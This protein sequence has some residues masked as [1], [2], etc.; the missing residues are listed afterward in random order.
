MP[1]GCI[2]V[3]RISCG[4]LAPARVPI[5]PPTSTA[6][7]FMAVPRPMTR[8]SIAGIVRKGVHV[9]PPLVVVGQDRV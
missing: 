8:A 6:T 5:P 2:A 4:N 9:P 1:V 3:E 7:T